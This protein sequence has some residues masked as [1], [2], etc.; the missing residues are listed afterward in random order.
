M[1]RTYGLTHVAPAVFETH[2]PADPPVSLDHHQ[3]PSS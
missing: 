3:P 2:T 1:I